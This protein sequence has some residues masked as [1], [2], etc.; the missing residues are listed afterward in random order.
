MSIESI[1]DF[2]TYSEKTNSDFSTA[3]WNNK[4]V[5]LLKERKYNI[6]GLIRP[7]SNQSLC[8]AKSYHFKPMMSSGNVT[9]SAEKDA[10]GDSN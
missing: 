1:S 10:D 8:N 3:I 4:E 6:L 7:V 9:V 5:E 2:D